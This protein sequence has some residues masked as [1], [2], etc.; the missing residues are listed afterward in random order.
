[1]RR[2]TLVLVTAVVV[3]ALS[4]SIAS[5]VRYGGGLHAQATGASPVRRLEPSMHRLRLTLGL[6]ATGSE[7]W[8]GAIELVGARLVRLRRVAGL[9]Q[10][11]G[12]SW[13]GRVQMRKR[14]GR[15]VGSPLVLDVL[16]ER[17]GGG[18]ELRVRTRQGEFSVR[19]GGRIEPGATVLALDGRVRI[20]RLPLYGFIADGADEE[21]F[22]AAAVAP[23]GTVWVAYVAYRH[24]NPIDFEAVRR[25]EFESLVT[26]GNGDQIRLVC[27]RDGVWR[28]LEPATVAG[29]DL[30]K[31][32]LA[33]ARDGKVWVVWSQNVDGNWDV[34]ARAYDPSAAKWGKRLRV[35]TNRGSDI[36][37]AVATRSTD[38][39][40]WCVWQGFVN[41]QFDIFLARL[42]GG[43]EPRPMVVSAASEANDWYPDVA[44]GPQGE[45]WVAW[46]SYAAGNYDVY[47]RRCDGQLRE[48]IAVAASLRY[49]GRPSIAVDRKGRL[50]VA[51]EDGDPNWGKDYGDR[52]PAKKGVPFY[53]ERNIVVRCVTSGRVRQTA[54][55]V[56]AAPVLTFFD[57]KRLKPRED[58]R[59]SIPELLVDSADRVWLFFRKHPLRTGSREVWLSYAALY[60]GDRWSEPRPL[61]ASANTLDRRPAVVPNGDGVLAIYATDHRGP[62]PGLE[63][64]D[65][66]AT[67]LEPSSKAAAAAL[68]EVD[69]EAGPSVEPV[70]PNEAEDVAR[71]RSYRLRVGNREYRLLR[72]EFHRH[73]ELSAHRDWDGPFEELWR[74]S[75]DAAA[76][77]WIGPGDHDYPYAMQREYN[78][79][80]TQKQIDMYHNPP[81]FVPMF[82]YERS[83]VYPSGHRNVMFAERGIR[84]LPR[85][86]GRQNLF[87]T[88]ERGS[89]D[90]QN[91]YR[92]LKHFGGICAVHTSATDMGTDW[93]D[94]DPEVEPVV[95]IFQGHRQNYEE[96]NAPLAPKGPDDAIQGYHLD[97]FVWNALAKGYRLG[98]QSSSDHV[99][100]HISYAIV[101]AAERS[102][103]GVLDALRRRHCYAAHDNIILDVRLGEAIMG[104]ETTV[105]GKP[106]LRIVVHGTAPI[107]RIDIVRQVGSNAPAYAY[108]FEPHR[109]DVDVRWVDEEAKAGT[110]YMYYVRIQQ[111]DKKLAWSSPIWVSCK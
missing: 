106:E 55:D 15:R 23:D 70:H 2:Y 1:M 102:R 82:T 40:V 61:P 105:S 57:D 86:P 111:V 26:R 33:V 77:D 103:E 81:Y 65:L 3:L 10:V 87:G 20:Q 13:T 108:A 67:F 64:N 16:L 11:R 100:T 66:V 94:N 41:G 79:W 85:L 43:A 63:D 19:V 78:W 39:S 97:G 58:H 104:D 29:L 68:R 80:F 84:T 53:W 109:R 59:I 62:A 12:N 36:N 76:M 17:V 49:E 52:W 35:S 74:Y 18:A 107:A 6:K 22:P 30:W 71:I 69:P 9:V 32:A 96:P 46:D 14:K 21:D 42:D 93:R 75:Y 73:T 92:Y 110:R 7:D 50:W 24:G 56:R 25:G 34:Y 48:P 31:P 60:S 89:P 8:S 91:L 95:E 4:A 45:L 72:G 38:G 90:V 5:V 44:V 27:Y 47:V 99:S 37:V 54:V 28:D 51:Y 98:F 88:P 83:V 101:I